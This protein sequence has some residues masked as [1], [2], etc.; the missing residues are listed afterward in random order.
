MSLQPQTIPPIPEET[1]RVARALFPE[2]NRYMRLR[3]EVGSIYTDKQFAA[4]YPAGGQFAEQPWRIALL[5]VMQHMENYTDRQAAEAMR[6]RIDWK[7]V[8]S[9]ELTDPGFDFSVLSEFRQRLIV[10][11]L[12][13]E[14]LNKLLQVCRERGWLKERGKQRTD[15][16]HVLAAIRTM[17][18]LECVAETLRAA[19]NS[20]AVVVPDWLRCQVPAAWYQQYGTRAEEY[21]FPKEATQRQA[22][23][24]QIGADGSRLLRAIRSADAPAWIAE[25]PAVEVLRRV[26][27]QQFWMDEGVVRWRS[28]QDIPPASILISS[29][30]DLEAHLSIKRSTVWTGF[31]LHLTET[32]DEELP[33]LL[34]HVATTPA[35]TQDMEMTEPIHQALAQKHLLPTEHA[36]DTGYVDGEHLVN[37]QKS[38]GVELLGPVTSSPSWQARAGQGFDHTGFTID[39]QAKQ[40]IC[41]QGKSSRKWTLKQDRTVSEVIRIQFGKQ[42]CLAC[43][44]RSQCTTASTNPRQLV[45]RPQAQF[46]AIQAARQRQQTQEFKERY[47]IRAGVEGTISQGVRAFGVRRSPYIGLAKTHLHHVLSATAINFSRLLAWLMGIP[48]DLTRVSR[49]AALAP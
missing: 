7:Y 25:V 45:V 43:P 19:L 10:A 42:D 21:R 24:E 38:Y 22:L 46:E 40:A 13:E 36:M 37:C 44:C 27:V 17:N 34:I 8:L 4:L 15:S 26:W 32:C 20:L 5:L 35:T 33:H 49:F 47:A 16:T 2:G 18:R 39:W 29:P 30:Y 48:F 11:G 31:K 14:L 12:E 1:A 41:P 3:D 23:T 28:D 9:L 6:T